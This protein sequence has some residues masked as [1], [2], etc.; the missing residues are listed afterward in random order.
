MFEFNDKVFYPGHGVANVDGIIEKEVA[1]SC[2]KFIK[3]SFLHKDMMILVP[4]YNTDSIGLRSISSEDCV[5]K[6]LEELH[7]GPERKLESI[8]FTPSGWNRRHKEYQLKILGGKLIDIIKI[9]RDLMYISQQKELSFGER[10]LLQS[11]EDLLA[12]E[13]QSVRKTSREEVIQELRCPFKQ[14]L[15]LA[16]SKISIKKNIAIST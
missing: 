6:V 7:R 3:L 1:G 9:Y 5:N 16:Q 8:D 4:L 2:L 10:T 11:V 15:N 13:I 12:Q 14:I